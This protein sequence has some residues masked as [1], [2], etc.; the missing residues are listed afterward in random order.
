MERPLLYER[1]NRRIDLM[2]RDGLID[3]VKSLL[4]QGYTESSFP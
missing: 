2:V 4:D 1:I 3:E